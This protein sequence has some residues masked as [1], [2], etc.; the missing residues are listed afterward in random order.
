MQSLFLLICS[1]LF[2]VYGGDEHWDLLALY[3]ADV[4][5][6]LTYQS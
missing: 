6:S 3:L 1:Y 4:A 2:V 5:V